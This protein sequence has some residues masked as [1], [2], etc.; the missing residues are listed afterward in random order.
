[1]DMGTIM[2]KVEDSGAL[3][4][5]TFEESDDM[6]DIDYSDGYDNRDIED[7]IDDELPDEW[8]ENY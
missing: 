5:K 4:N 2:D 8:H 1:M 3:S 7:A 6:Y